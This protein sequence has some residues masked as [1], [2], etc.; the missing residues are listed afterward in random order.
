MKVD[1]EEV[2]TAIAA[3]RSVAHGDDAAA[4]ETASL[5]KRG[6]PDSVRFLRH[7]VCN[8]GVSMP[9]RIRAACTLLEVGGYLS[10]Y[11]SAE[12]R[13]TGAFREPADGAAERNEA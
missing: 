13:I 4:A 10:G 1:Q 5:A 6:G 2:T 8:K 9:Q 3:A 12:T 11:P 7:V